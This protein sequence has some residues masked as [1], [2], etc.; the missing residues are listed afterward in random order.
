MK[1][2]RKPVTVQALPVDGI[3][4]AACGNDPVAWNALPNWVREA[5]GSGK[6]YCEKEGTPRLNINGTTGTVYAAPGDFLIRPESSGELFHCPPDVFER[7]Y[8]PTL[9]EKG[10]CPRYEPRPIMVEA[11]PVR[12]LVSNF[13]HERGA[14]WERYP[15]WVADAL[16]DGTIKMQNPPK[17]VKVKTPGGMVEAALDAYL[18]RDDTGTIN[19]CPGATFCEVYDCTITWPSMESL[20]RQPR[21]V[22]AIPVSAILNGLYNADLKPWPEWLREAFG[23]GRITSVPWNNTLRLETSGG[24][25]VAHPDDIILRDQRGE[26]TVCKRNDFL[27]NYSALSDKTPPGSAGQYI[28]NPIPVEPTPVAESPAPAVPTPDPVQASTP[29][30]RYKEKP[31]VVEAIQVADILNAVIHKVN[32]FGLP[33]WVMC[34]MKCG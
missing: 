29:A 1:Y 25:A 7:Q 3:L 10:T 13:F 6:I 14:L 23:S 11:Y 27:G 17:S 21:N 26:L 15:Q 20:S 16:N 33:D 8:E 34:A 2:A 30:A 18:V 28:K 22:E 31:V 24:E 19:P 32:P 5:I 4:D 12:D 9:Y